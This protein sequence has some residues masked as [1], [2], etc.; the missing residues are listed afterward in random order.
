MPKPQ[1]GFPCHNRTPK[2]LGC[3][4]TLHPNPRVEFTTCWG[5]VEECWVAGELWI[6]H[7]KVIFFPFSSG[8]ACANHPLGVDQ[9]YQR[10]FLWLCGCPSVLDGHAHKLQGIRR[11]FHQVHERATSPTRHCWCST[12]HDYPGM[13]R[14]RIIKGLKEWRI[15]FKT[16]IEERFE[17][18][19]RFLHNRVIRLPQ[20][21]GLAL[22]LIGDEALV[23][24]S[25][26]RC[27]L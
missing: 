14:D 11:S 21:I 13:V 19:P 24:Y 18:R 17:M 4:N 10:S 2:H 22:R 8:S 12:S 5:R 20:R 7:M 3:L 23:L 25:L 27:Y 6:D 1:H 15:Y 9:S 26:D 16:M